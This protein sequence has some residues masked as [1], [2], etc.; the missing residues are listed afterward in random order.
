MKTTDDKTKLT[1]VFCLE[2]DILKVI[3]YL[4]RY[5]ILDYYSVSSLKSS[6]CSI[7]FKNGGGEP[8]LLEQ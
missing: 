5:I 6:D 8:V 1:P 4:F 2:N 7:F 3:Y